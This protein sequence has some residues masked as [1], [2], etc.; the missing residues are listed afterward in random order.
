MRVMNI[1]EIKIGDMIGIGAHSIVYSCMIGKDKYALKLLNYAYPKSVIDNIY[2]MTDKY[3]CDSYIIPICIVENNAGDFLGY[4]MK[5][6]KSLKPSSEI[7]EKKDKISFLKN[8]R[9]IIDVLHNDYK[10]IHGDLVDENMLYNKRTK[11]AYLID[12]DASLKLGQGYEYTQLVRIFLQ[13]YLKYYK[14]DNNMDTY[15]FNLTTL[16][17]LGNYDYVQMLFNDISC[18]NYTFFDSLDGSNVVRDNECVKRLSKELLLKN[19]RN[20]YSGEYIIDY[21]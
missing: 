15:L 2:E 11:K 18:D 9:N 19:T 8:A 7:K 6:N 17:L 1:K 16:K 10:I 4:I 21:I 20:E 12:F 5:Y 3:F 13:N 14:V